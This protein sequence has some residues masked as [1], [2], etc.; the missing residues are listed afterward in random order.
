MVVLAETASQY[1]S[2][3]E[4]YRLAEDYGYPDTDN[5]DPWF[6]LGV[7]HYNRK[8]MEVAREKFLQTLDRLDTYRGIGEGVAQGSIMKIY[9]WL[10][11]ACLVLNSPKETVRYCV[12]ALRMN[13][14]QD[15]V[16]TAILQLLKQESGESDQAEGTWGFLQNL[17]D[18]QSPKDLL[19]LLKCAKLAGFHALENR[20]LQTM[21]EELKRESQKPSGEEAGRADRPAQSESRRADTGILNGVCSKEQQEDLIRELEERGLEHMQAS[22]SV[23]AQ[24]DPD[25][26]FH[27]A[28]LDWKT[29]DSMAERRTQY[30]MLLWALRLLAPLRA[31]D[32]RE[33]CQKL[34]E[35]FVSLAE[36]LLP[37]IY[38]PALLGDE[39]AWAVLPAT[40]RFGLWMRRA[41]ETRAT[42]DRLEYIRRLRSGLEQAPG[43]K[44]MVEFLIEE[45]DRTEEPAQ[46]AVQATP[47][48]RQLAEQVKAILSQ[49]APD[50]PV[51][52]QLKAS[53]A[54][55]KVATLLEAFED[56]TSL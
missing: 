54:Y 9:T 5:P 39:E 42:E 19:F 38:H 30:E 46:E 13:R 45:M 47:E 24:E 15:R 31:A 37:Q 7:W 26:A 17:Y 16:L 52:R 36:A 1:D 14:Y 33:L 51:V 21:P 27:M 22:V 2:S 34:Y 11:Q 40:D 55:Q 20:V 29:G 23:L 49:Y 18:F 6:L 56:P 44:E 48:L 3:R 43:M 32:E 28:D 53:P 50:D 25:F 41:K 4:I 8:E 12:L 35:R 10:A